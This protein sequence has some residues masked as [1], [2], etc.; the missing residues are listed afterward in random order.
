MNDWQ[1]LYLFKFV[2]FLTLLIASLA[3][4]G[5]SASMGGPYGRD[6][7]KNPY[8]CSHNWYDGL[9]AGAG[10]TYETGHARTDVTP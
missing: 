10:L 9:T 6:C 4:M 1:L 3:V 5:C 7:T 2:V 8:D